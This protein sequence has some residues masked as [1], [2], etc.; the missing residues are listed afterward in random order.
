MSNR[1]ERRLIFQM[2]ETWSGWFCS[3]C[4]WNRPLPSG[5]EERIALGSRIRC[6]FLQHVCAWERSVATEAG[7]EMRVV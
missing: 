3:A 6:E 1:E 2:A 7:D 5:W 4:L